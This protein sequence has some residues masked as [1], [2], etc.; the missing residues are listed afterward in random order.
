VEQGRASWTARWVASQRAG[1]HDQRPAQGDAGA[2]LRLYQGLAIPLLNARLAGPTGMAAPTRFVDDQLLQAVERDVRQVVLIGAGYDGRA[3]RFSD[4]PVRWIEV[5]HVATQADK[6]RRLARI[7]ATTDHIRFVPV[8]LLEGS[9]AAEL[10]KAGH[11]PSQPSLSVCE[12]LF[13]YLPTP[14]ISALCQTLRD[15]SS[16]GSALVCNMLVNDVPRPLTRC[17]RKAVDSLLAAI[18]ERRLSEFA[19]GDSERL[20]ADAGWE[21]QRRES[22]S[23]GRT[24]GTYLLAIMAV[25]VLR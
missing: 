6:R 23:P 4:L 24:D 17:V 2:E 13:P 8:D 16:P 12:G 18:G 20:L 3:L 10:A 9:L 1:L 15:R 19:P 22:T 14:T 7:G 11:D 21:V 5:D 25:P